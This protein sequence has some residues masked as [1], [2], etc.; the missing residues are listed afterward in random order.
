MNSIAMY[1]LVHIATEYVN[2]SLVIHLG[3]APFNVLG[4]VFA[5][6]LIGGTTLLVFWGLLYWMY[7]QRVF[8]RI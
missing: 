2:R 7:R 1:L 3:A 4:P 8:I 6:V 5:P